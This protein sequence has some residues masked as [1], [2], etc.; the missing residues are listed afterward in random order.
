VPPRH[1]PSTGQFVDE[2][3]NIAPTTQDKTSTESLLIVPWVW[4][5]GRN[6]PH[7]AAL[8]G[9]AL[10]LVVQLS[11]INDLS[12]AVE[13]SGSSMFSLLTQ[14]HSSDKGDWHGA[15]PQQSHK[16][17]FRIDGLLGE[18]NSFL[19]KPETLPMKNSKDSV[20]C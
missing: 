7:A 13:S 17:F 1:K 8:D 11:V 4:V 5:E 14:S 9:Q 18:R 19:E 15:P 3:V 2:D 6:L 16:S 10:A 20:K 12:K